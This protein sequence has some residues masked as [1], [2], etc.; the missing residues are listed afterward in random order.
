MLNKF[1]PRGGQVGEQN[2]LRSGKYY[3]DRSTPAW[4]GATAGTMFKIMAVLR[5]PSLGSLNRDIE[6]KIAVLGSGMVGH[7]IATNL[8]SG[9]RQVIM[10][11]PTTNRSASTSS[12]GL[13]ERRSR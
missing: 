8:V 11:S 3:P 6:M 10:G 12:F 2:S 5:L 7:A 1:W 13:A 4:L 9:G